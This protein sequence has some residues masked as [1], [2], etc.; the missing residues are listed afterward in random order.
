MT[1]LGL[2]QIAGSHSHLMR[3][4]RRSRRPICCGVLWRW[5]DYSVLRPWW[6]ISTNIFAISPMLILGDPSDG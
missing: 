1:H 2:P 4:K 3:R 5:M 6:L